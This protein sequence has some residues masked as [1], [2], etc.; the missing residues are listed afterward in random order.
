MKQVRQEA[1][2][3][4][5]VQKNQLEETKALLV[6][7]RKKSTLGRSNLKKSTESLD[8]L[9]D[10]DTP[11]KVTHLDINYK[12]E[13]TGY[14][15]LMF[16][17]S[18]EN[19]DLTTIL[20]HFCADVNVQDNKGNT[21]LHLAVFNSQ[22]KIVNLL[23][24]KGAKVDTAN[25][26]GNT[27]LHIACQHYGIGDKF[28]LLKLLQTKPNVTAKN[29]DGAMPLDLAAQYDKQEAVSML[30]DHEPLLRGS[31]RAFHEAAIRGHCGVLQLMLDY[32]IDPNVRDEK[33]E[34]TALHEACRYLRYDAAKLLMSYGA[35]P[36]IP[37]INDETPKVILSAYP[38]EKINKFLKL[39]QEGG[40]LTKLRPKYTESPTEV[41]ETVTRN[42]EPE[43]MAEGAQE[44]EVH[45]DCKTTSYIKWAVP[46]APKV[47]V[48]AT[49]PD[50]SVEG[51][52]G[53]TE[54]VELMVEDALVTGDNVYQLLPQR[55]DAP[56][57][58]VF[59]N[60]AMLQ[61]GTYTLTVRSLVN[62]DIYT[63][64]TVTV[65]KEVQAPVDLESMFDEL[66]KML[67]FD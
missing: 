4:K 21:P 3:V 54:D 10:V 11:E 62:P 57:L 61:E 55:P 49:M 51:D 27:P 35:D 37:D 64:A 1:K 60:I 52:A 43:V 30:L 48:D 12:D 38:P 56:S 42:S 6:S 66:E 65:E 47:F 40:T 45:F 14:T 17:V 24:N 7:G 53:I 33:T 22:S 46:P 16:A 41:K 8:S 28:L 58:A 63:S 31:F 23:L 67:Q 39:F 19:V 15:A 44:D 5:L 18:N 29:K 32:G 34:A 36:N 20:I 2:L 13:V 50:F 9:L 25:K 59:S 26:D